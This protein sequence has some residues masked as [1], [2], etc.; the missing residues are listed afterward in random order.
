MHKNDPYIQDDPG[1]GL[2]RKTVYEF[3]IKNN[4]DKWK[5]W[6]TND[7][8][9][10]PSSY[11]SF[12]LIENPFGFGNLILLTT[13]FDPDST[14]RSFGGFGMRAP[15]EPALPV[16]FE[17]YV[18]FD[19][20]Y[21]KDAA[22]Q[23]MR[24]EVWSTSSGG[25]GAQANGGSSGTN[26]TPIYI[27]TQ[28]LEG[29]NTYNIHFRCGYYKEETWYKKTISA[30]IPVT[31]ENWEFL[32]I[33][34][35]TETDT[36]VNGGLLMIGNIRITEK[37]PNG[38]PI[39]DVINEKLFSDVPPLKGK[40]N[41]DNG[42]FLI[43]T[44]GAE[45]INPETIGG[46]HF[47]LFVSHRNLKPEKHLRP[48]QWLK[49]EYPD[50]VFKYDSEGPEW[51]LPTDYY[52]NIRAAGNYKLHGHC[53]AWHNQSP[54]WMNQIIP[55][56]ITSIQWNSNGLFYSNGHFASKPFVKVKKETAR[57][58][59]FNHIIYE[60]RHFMTCDTRY[61]SSKERGI[62]PFHSF[63]VV[64]SEIHESR[65]SFLFQKNPNEWKTSLKHVSWL[66]AM[67]DNDYSDIRQHYIYLL[68][69][70]AHIAVPNAEMA[71]KYKENFINPDIIPGYMK[72]DNHDNNGSIDE[73]INEEPPVL[74][75]NDYEVISYSKAKVIYNMIKE[76]NAVWKT[77]PLY[78][79]RNLIECIGIQGHETVSPVLATYNHQ[80]VSLFAELIDEELLDSICFSEI[81][82]RQPY[83][84]PG[85]RALAPAILNQKQAD[86]IGYQ[87]AL[88]FK[89]FEKYRKYI[90]HV[91]LWNQYGAGW[92]NSYVLFDHEKKASKAYYAAM[93]PDKY[94]QGHSYLECYFSGEYEKIKTPCYTKRQ[95]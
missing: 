86:V 70:Y 26:R 6:R 25:E 44:D 10:L 80:A 92:Q 77:D 94:I 74:I 58:I 39:P 65:H 21:S 85:G 67:T 83:S 76:L 47:D 72:L 54:Q 84:A 75:Y 32:N 55:E 57:R 63:D 52:L 33:D 9:I 1:A 20:Y 91:I 17:T 14:K 59:H 38:V 81:D 66:M 79:G 93:D 40:Y 50:F 49:D 19:F 12:N 51:D 27:R 22:D 41:P 61:N 16:N 37:D 5:P 4:F 53:L 18:E 23:Y 31:G 36:K 73:Y 29:V 82:M 30:A 11:N 35:H 13:F 8:R 89:I 15:I 46:Y 3:D 62:I 88:L 43:G 48:P 45:T 56:N 24:F 68:F 90:D 64:N 71:K 7:G 42:Y 95:Q 34:L 28:E 78:D 69:K 60:M 2:Q 87:Y